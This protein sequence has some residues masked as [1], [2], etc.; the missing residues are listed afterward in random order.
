ML[1]ELGRTDIPI[2]TGVRTEVKPIN[3]AKWLGDYDLKDHPGKVYEDGVQALIDTIKATPGEVTLIVIG[4]QT[5]IEE[6]LKRDPSIA[7]K[8][9][10]VAMAGSVRIG[11]DGGPKPQAEWNVVCDPKAAQAVFAAPWKITYAPLDICGQLRLT[12]DDYLKVEKSDNP[13]SKVIIENYDLW[14]NRGHHPKDSSSILYDTAAVYLA[15]DESLATMED[16]K[17][18]ISDK[19]DTVLDEN[20]RTVR[21]GTGWKDEQ[22]F[23]DLLVKSL[24][25]K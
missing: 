17:L 5:N 20:G 14:V 4:G 11:Y 1:Q 24:T 9:R 6:A 8:A 25:G 15:F 2:G 12:G 18:S 23:K 10:V 22:G 7:E 13:L 3:Q 21:I 19:G 16:V